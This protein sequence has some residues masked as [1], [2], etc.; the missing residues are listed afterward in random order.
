M[1]TGTL[2]QGSDTNKMGCPGKLDTPTE[3]TGL[4]VY[5]AAFTGGRNLVKLGASCNWR[6]QHQAKDR[7]SNTVTGTGW[8]TGRQA[9][10]QRA[11]F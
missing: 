10:Q 6:T 9:W 2:E 3:M 1:P 7:V 4:E 11:R 8:Q 5:P